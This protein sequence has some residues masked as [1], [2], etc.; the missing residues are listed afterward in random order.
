MRYIV[1]NDKGEVFASFKHRADAFAFAGMGGTM[2]FTVEVGA[3]PGLGWTLV[4]TAAI[5][6]SL[7]VIIDALLTLP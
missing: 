2:N 4:Y 7:I 1:R 3:D 6:V 5:I